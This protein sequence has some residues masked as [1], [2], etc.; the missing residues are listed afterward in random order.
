MKPIETLRFLKAK[1]RQWQD[2]SYPER[3]LAHEEIVGHADSVWTDLEVEMALSLFLHRLARLSER[4]I[5]PHADQAWSLQRTV[6][7]VEGE[8]VPFEGLIDVVSALAAGWRVKWT[9]DPILEGAVD[10]FL[11]SL[12]HDAIGRVTSAGAGEVHQRVH[13]PSAESGEEHSAIDV[14][15]PPRA[16]LLVLDKPVG[17]KSYERLA[18]ELLLFS[19]RSER[20]IRMIAARPGISVDPLLE[21]IA[22]TIP[23]IRPHPR[24]CARNKMPAALMEAQQIPV[25][26][27][28][29]YEVLVTKGD[30]E[31]PSRFGQIR[32]IPWEDPTLDP[33][34][35]TLGETSLWYGVA[36]DPNIRRTLQQ[37][38]ISE[39]RLGRVFQ[40]PFGP[41]PPGRSLGSIL[42]QYAV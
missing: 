40:E 8:R 14:H 28:T 32:W 18:Q 26:Y 38:N 15:L 39:G 33:I 25:A 10:R 36:R 17:P 6:H 5:R 23:Q 24:I 16:S 42:H 11:G 29:G 1:A 9:V 22:H 3:K 30:A 4:I 27:T 41:A 21:A 31:I 19:G 2:P 35:N 13:H 12:S 37:R 34:L 20:S 7:F